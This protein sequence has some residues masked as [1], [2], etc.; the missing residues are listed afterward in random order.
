MSN[1]EDMIKNISN[2]FES[3]NNTNVLCLLGYNQIGYSPVKTAV[4][5]VLNL[6][7]IDIRVL[8]EEELIKSI[9][10]YLQ[11]ENSSCL[12]VKKEREIQDHTALLTSEIC[13]AISEL[14]NVPVVLDFKD[15]LM[16]S[17]SKDIVKQHVKNYINQPN[18]KSMY[19]IDICELANKEALVSSQ[20]K[21]LRIPYEN[22][23]LFSRHMIA[24][25]FTMD[26]FL[27]YSSKRIQEIV[28][29]KR[30]NFE[31]CNVRLANIPNIQKLYAFYYLLG[32][33]EGLI[34]TTEL[35]SLY[36]KFN[37]STLKII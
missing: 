10:E 7:S 1:L 31:L 30:E 16:T 3:T 20:L 34:T 23:D 21:S 11:L 35:E 13:M 27:N 5:S 8:N 37:P 29:G 9:N 17:V 32:F 2:L 33:T 19:W 24:G 6:Y 36:L 14:I 12:I 4:T 15:T 25:G 22:F 26:Y 18:D 28:T